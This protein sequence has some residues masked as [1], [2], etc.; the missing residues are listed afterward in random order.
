MQNNVDFDYCALYEERCAAI[1]EILSI[2]QIEDKINSYYY[3]DENKIFDCEY[4][5][6]IPFLII[7]TDL[8]ETVTYEVDLFLLPETEYDGYNAVILNTF[9]N[10][11]FRTHFYEEFTYE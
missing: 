9:E 11:D 2:L 4:S 7:P 1:T 6:G 5:N 8:L 10:N 3:D